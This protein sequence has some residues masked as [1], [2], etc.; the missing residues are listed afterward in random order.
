MQVAQIN[1]NRNT[2]FKNGFYTVTRELDSSAMLS[3]SVID[4]FG[5]TI[6]WIVMSNNSIERR[7]RARKFLFDYAVIYMTPFLTLPFTNRLA[8]KY[9]G[10]LTKNLWSNNHKAIH[11][12]NEF[13]KDTDTM[14]NE[15]RRMENKT[16]R[17]PFEVLFN[18][19]YPKKKYEQKID[20][21]N[22]LKSCN[23]DKEV[24]RQKLIN[25][26]NAVF[27]SDSILTFGTLGSI[28]FINNEITK[29][30]TGQKGFSAEMS[31]AD[32][33][34]VEKRAEKYEKTK[35][36]RFLSFAAATAST[37]A[38]MSLAGF[39]SLKSKD[40]GKFL[41]YLKNNARAFD[42]VK[43]I[44]MSR[45]PLFIGS[46]ITLTGNM[47]AARNTTERKDMAIRQGIGS[48]VFFGGDLLLASMFTNLSDRLFNTKLRKEE[49]NNSAIN[50]ILPKV[51]PVKQILEEVETGKI[52]GVN[53]KVSAG[54]FWANMLILMASMGYLVPKAIN[55]M[56]KHDVEMDSKDR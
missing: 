16:T 39:L 46:L 55:K 48:A 37:T 10:K 53:K 49:N 35:S 8:M 21:E 6:P 15:L 45:F 32:K 40:S 33:E 23:G 34:I 42:Y 51:K 52:S 44:Y 56:I 38:L 24:L 3:R 41:Q 27:I 19:L 7:E 14:M 29:S 22:L 2:A 4:L 18:K 28:P 31:M 12:S 47:L 9:V 11:I 50:K 30:Q 25:S 36:K 26:K 20:T 43:G 17:G 54:I 13:L 1:T 5:C